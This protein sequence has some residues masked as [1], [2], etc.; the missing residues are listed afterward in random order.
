MSQ[1]AAETSLFGLSRQAADYVKIEIFIE[2][3]FLEKKLFSE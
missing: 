2:K 1:R 3:L